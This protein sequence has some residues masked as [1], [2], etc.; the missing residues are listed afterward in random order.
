MGGI[1]PS[2]GQPEPQEPGCHVYPWFELGIHL[3]HLLDTIALCLE[4]LEIG[5]GVMAPAS[6][7]LDFEVN[8]EKLTSE[9]TYWS[10]LL[11]SLH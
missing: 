7:S 2:L 5:P 10:V 4:T 1:A 3:V 6:W 9:C 8:C 11:H